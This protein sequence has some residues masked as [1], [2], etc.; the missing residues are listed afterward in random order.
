MSFIEL[1]DAPHCLTEKGPGL[2]HW[3]IDYG[4]HA[5][6]L[7]GVVLDK[8]GEIWWVPTPKLTVSPNWSLGQ[9]GKTKLP[10]PSGGRVN[11]PDEPAR[12]E[13]LLKLIKA[14]P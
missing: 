2:A 13:A 3:A 7:F 10:D 6:V 11:V 9:H 12:T 14:N 5:D 8:T 4:A 1:A